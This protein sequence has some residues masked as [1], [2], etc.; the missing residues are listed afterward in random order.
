MEQLTVGDP[1]DT[2]TEIGP[3]ATAAILATLDQQVQ[4]S[5]AAGA[6]LLS[7]GQRLDRPGHYYA[8]TVLANIPP[9]RQRTARSYSARLRRCSA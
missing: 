9:I 4:Q 1:L 6:R 2:T 8:P 3:L 5:L 7:G